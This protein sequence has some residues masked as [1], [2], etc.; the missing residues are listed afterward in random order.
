MHLR[1]PI[2]YM[3]WHIRCNTTNWY[4]HHQ[5]I[6]IKSFGFNEFSKHMN[7][8]SIKYLHE[9][10]IVFNLTIKNM[11]KTDHKIRIKNFW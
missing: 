8:W 2:Q 9:I 7:N 3:M 6:N 10:K 11:E 1:W 4:I 5:L